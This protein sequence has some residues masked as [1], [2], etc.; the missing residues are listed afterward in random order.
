MAEKL[1]GRGRP[2]RTETQGFDRAIRKAAL[3]VL[4]EQ[5]EAASM[6]AVAK[7][8]GLSRKTL[9]ARYPNKEE[10]FLEVIGGLLQGVRRL[11]YDARGAAEDRLLHYIEAACEQISRPEAQAIQ[12]LLTANPAYIAALRSDMLAATRKRFLEPLHALLGDAMISGELV[13]DDVEET[14][15][16]ILRLILA[17]TMT[18]DGDA[19]PR[20]AHTE[21]SDYPAFLAR[22]IARGLVPRD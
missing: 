1:R 21:Q 7:A 22:L 17:E 9:Y 16:V 6:N 19:P 15:R 2:K 5:G 18:A 11:D 12:R 3:Q 14:A 13:L 20:S 10:L 4:L 8:A